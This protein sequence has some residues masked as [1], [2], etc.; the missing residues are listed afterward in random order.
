M[1]SL[2]WHDYLVKPFALEELVARLQSLTRRSYGVKSAS[3]PVGDMVINTAQRVVVRN[4]D[5]I[6]LKPREYCLL[7]YLAFRRGTVVSRSDIE[8]HIYDERVEPMSNVVDSAICQLRRKID[9]PGGPSL[10][11]TRRGMGYILT[12]SGE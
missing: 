7:E 6:A 1:I 3:L 2:K 9:P 10:I 12:E 4:G 5:L 8:Y 11:E